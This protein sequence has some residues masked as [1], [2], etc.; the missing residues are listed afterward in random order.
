[1]RYTT[2][3]IKAAASALCFTFQ[4]QASD[5]YRIGASPESLG[6]G[7][8]AGLTGD[9]LA[10]MSANPALLS[11]QSRQVVIS[12]ESMLVN[13]ELT[14]RTG[15]QVSA[16]KG[17]A[18]VPQVAASIPV[19][20]SLTLG[21]GAQ[22]QSGM[23]ASFVYNDPAGT[24]GVSYGRQVHESGYLVFNTAAALSWALN[25]DLSVGIQLGLAYNRNQLEAPYIF[26]SHPALKG[27]K[28]LVDLEVDEISPSLALGIN[29][30]LTEGT[31]F[32]L[33]WGIENSFHAEGELSGNLSQ[34]GLGI[35]E[36]FRYQAVVD[37][38]LPAFVSVGLIHRF[39]PVLRGGLQVDWINWKNTFR[40]L[41]IHLT[42]GSNHDL[43]SFL[44][45]NSIDDTA[46]LDWDNQTVVHLGG[47]YQ[48]HGRHYR[49]GYEHAD[50]PVPTTTFTPMTGAIFRHAF[51]AGAGFQAG[52]MPVDVYYRFSTSGDATRVNN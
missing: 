45:S 23:Q 20:N 6:M 8:V 25:D 15:E 26:Q 7:S 24:L 48:R 50:V 33:G 51:M 43:N 10:A 12:V 35:Q 37:T 17:P 42:E 16:D 39:N 49:I 52:N 46:P 47:E 40:E 4:L 28:V 22:V 29:Y 11:G 30:R 13:A 9:P 38:G 27:L 5:L 34:L 36:D 14:T 32:N 2:V 1:M 44:G 19:G 31:S 3:R 21:L 41:P 18:F